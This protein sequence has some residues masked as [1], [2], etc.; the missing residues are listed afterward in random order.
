MFKFLKTTKNTVCD[1]AYWTIIGKIRLDHRA[2]TY[3]CHRE[4]TI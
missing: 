4:A 3:H 1:C 2:R